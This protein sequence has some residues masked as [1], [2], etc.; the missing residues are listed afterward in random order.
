MKKPFKRFKKTFE[1]KANDY[2]KSMGIHRKDGEKKT[3]R[4]LKMERKKLGF[5]K[6]FKSILHEWVHMK[7][8]QKTFKKLKFKKTKK[9]QT[10]QK[11]KEKNWKPKILFFY[12][13]KGGTQE[14]WLKKC[15]KK[16]KK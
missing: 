16:L 6:I 5:Q 7:N 14:R 1:K 9:K 13:I 2:I 12:S 11:K 15:L 4:K 10:K 8:N 3:L